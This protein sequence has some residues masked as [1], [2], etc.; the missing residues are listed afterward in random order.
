M[1]NITHETLEKKA[2]EFL[3]RKGCWL[4]Q[5]EVPKM[6]RLSPT[7]KVKVIM[8]VVGAKK[9]TFGTKWYIIEAKVSYEDF[10]DKRRLRQYRHY[11]FGAKKYF[12]S[13]RKVILESHLRKKGLSSWGLLW[14]LRNGQV[15]V[16]KKA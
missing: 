2:I 12:I 14:V 5:Y 7:K 9:S 15:E 4:V 8:D 13:P 16:V 3:R 10:N 6:I 1:N 11:P